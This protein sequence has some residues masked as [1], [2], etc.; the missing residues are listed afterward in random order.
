MIYR[1]RNFLRLAT[2]YDAVLA[3]ITLV[4]TALAGFAGLCFVASLLWALPQANA[5][6]TATT[7]ADH[8]PVVLRPAAGPFASGSDPSLP[9]AA[10]ALAGKPAALDNATPTF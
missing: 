9:T 8:A 7:R 6:D 4:A 5:A 10:L 2:Q 3:R 1:K